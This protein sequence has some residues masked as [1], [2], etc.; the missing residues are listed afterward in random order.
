MS[1]AR[2]TVS[3]SINFCLSDSD[4]QDKG[5][6]RLGLEFSLPSC[7]PLLHVLSLKDVVTICK[8]CLIMELHMNMTTSHVHI[9]IVQRFIML[10]V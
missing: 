1:G 8:G 2:S 3:T 5:T 10:C 9:Y 4:S 6:S 7:H